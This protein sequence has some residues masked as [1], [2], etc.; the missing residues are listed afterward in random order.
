MSAG[1]RI[2]LVKID[3]DR[4]IHP[5]STI[6]LGDALKR[7]GYDVRVFNIFEGEMEGTLDDILSMDPVFVGFSVLTG[8]Q[9]KISARMSEAVKKR[10]PGIPVVWGGVHPSILPED[11][12]KESFVDIVGMGE[13]EEMV[14]ELAGALSEKRPLDGIA[15]VGYKSPDGS[16]KINPRRAFLPDL[17]KYRPDWSLEKDFNRCVSVLP[18]GRRQVDFT[19]SRGCPFNCAF[20]YNLSFNQRRWRKYSFEYVIN[21]IKL[22]KERYDVRAIQFHDDNFFVDLERAFGI[23]E[24]IKKMDV[25][26]TSCMIR[27]DLV[28]EDILKRLSR[29][30]TKRIFVGWES[31]SERIL[32]LINKGLTRELIIEKFKL[33]AKFPELAVTAA[34]II[35]FP[36]ETWEDIC[37]TIDMGVRLAAI[38]PNIVITYQT[39]IPYPGSHL[40]GMAR[41][42]GFS[43]PK[44]MSGYESFDTFTGEMKL[45]WLPWA[46]AGTQQLFYRIDKYGKLLTHSPGSSAVRTLGKRFFYEMARLR[47]RSKFFA[48]P[49]E[50]EVL[51]RFNRYYNPKCRF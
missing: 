36:T 7:A 51:H 5:L 41:K 24:S 16:F 37:E 13:G 40:Y 3:C 39:F 31:G 50:I 26:S 35:G 22:L 46:D 38:L 14:V 1:K 17:D 15:G 25:I 33:I 21:E 6:Y 23:L 47:L 48:M 8:L 19:A 43:L 34:S 28:N 27:L 10:A 44:D 32:R 12:L 2:A 45:N 29:L 9:T 18:D 49:F 30:G 11:C 20:C 42:E 4:V